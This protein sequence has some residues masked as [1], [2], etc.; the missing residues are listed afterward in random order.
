MGAKSGIVHI[1]FPLFFLAVFILA[2]AILYSVFFKGK[3]NAPKL[4]FQ[5]ESKV[6]VKEDYTNPFDKE[7]Q[8]LNPFSQYKSPFENIK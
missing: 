6:A 2:A 4:P 3:I 5:K 7:A 1:L 8:Y